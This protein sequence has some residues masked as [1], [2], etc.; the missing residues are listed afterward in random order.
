[1]PQ[2]E[3]LL[4]PPSRLPRNVKLLGWTSFFN[5]V[6]SEMIY[7][8]MPQFLIAVLGGNRFHLGVIVPALL[9]LILIGGSIIVAVV[10]LGTTPDKTFDATGGTRWAS[11]ARIE[12][13]FAPKTMR[14]L[15]PEQAVAWNAAAPTVA[16]RVE[17]A[18][19]FALRTGKAEYPVIGAQVRTGGEPDAEG[20][21]ITE[22]MPDT[23]AERAG[24]QKDDVIT[25]VGDQP[26]NDGIALIVAVR[27]HRPGET[28][29]MSVI[30]GGE[31][32]VVQVELD[33]KVG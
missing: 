2:T 9:A 11:T 24:L 17:S 29:E 13:P 14:P 4:Q 21:T 22:V 27:T 18:S 28:V 23:P 19:T 1:M 12:A 16:K 5:D 25:S 31:E 26:V 33:G 15:T 3:S 20:A 6:A 10:S 8:L 32:Q 7:P 30:R